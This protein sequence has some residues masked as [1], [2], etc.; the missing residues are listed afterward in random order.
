LLCSDWVLDPGAT[1]E[2]NRGSHQFQRLYANISVEEL[3]KM[4]ASKDFIFVNVHIPFEGDLPD[5]TTSPSI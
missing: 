5:T 3:H 1:I 4:L 2:A